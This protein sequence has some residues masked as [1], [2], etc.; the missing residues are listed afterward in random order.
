M[1]FG[2]IYL[3]KNNFQQAITEFENSANLE[4]DELRVKYNSLGLAY[5]KT[6][7]YGNAEK[8]LTIAIHAVGCSAH[9]FAV[10]RFVC[11]VRMVQ[12]AQLVALAVL[13]PAKVREE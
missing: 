4:P 13:H 6:G 11:I 2:A 7:R 3:D 8:A 5:I 1:A 9:I 10:C 12:I